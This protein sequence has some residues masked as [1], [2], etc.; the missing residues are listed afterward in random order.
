MISFTKLSLNFNEDV[1]CLDYS[2]CAFVGLAVSNTVGLGVS[3]DVD[4]GF[5]SG[6]GI[7][8]WLFTGN[9]LRLVFHLS[10]YYLISVNNILFSLSA[11]FID[12]T[13]VRIF[14]F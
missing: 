9:I 1:L 10:S 8:F 11:A 6:V 3:S 14:L 5:T 4:S 13:L 7:L 12:K 2:A